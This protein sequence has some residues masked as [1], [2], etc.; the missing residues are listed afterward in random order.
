MTDRLK[1]LFAQQ[2][3][4]VGDVAGNAD[5]LRQARADGAE[6]GADLVV[7]SELMITGYPLIIL[8]FLFSLLSISAITPKT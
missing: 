2:N 4:T 7:S 6:K 3:P 5:L 1:I 8:G